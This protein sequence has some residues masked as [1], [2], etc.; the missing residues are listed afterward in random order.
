MIRRSKGSVLAIVFAVS[1]LIGT[2]IAHS[3]AAANTPEYV[4]LPVNSDPSGDPA[5]EPP[6]SPEPPAPAPPPADP[7]VTEVSPPAAPPAPEPSTS[8]PA[9]PQ[10]TDAAVESP[11]QAPPTT[12]LIVASTPQMETLDAPAPAPVEAA[13]VAAGAPVITIFAGANGTWSGAPLTFGVPGLAQTD[14]NVLGRVTDPDGIKSITYKLNSR[15]PVSMS[16]GTTSCAVGISCT[17]RLAAD[18]DFNAD[19]SAGLLLAGRNTVTIRA[20]DTTSA[21]TTVKVP[22]QYTRGRTWALPYRVQWSTVTRPD[23][24]SQVVDGRWRL[25]PAGVRTMEIG[26]DRLIAFGDRSWSSFE[27][28]VAV[29]VHRVDPNGYAP[30]STAPGVGFIPH[31]LGHADVDGSQPKW[32]FRG[33][34]GALVW[35]RD[36]KRV[37]IRNT[38]AK[39]MASAGRT[40][41][42]GVTYVLKIRAVTGGTMGPEYR[43]K[44]FPL[45]SSE[46]ARW[47]LTKTVPKGG[48]EQGSLVLVAHHMD[49][50]F[51]D[52]TV[53]R[54]PSR[55]TG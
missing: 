47:D 52:L 40:L 7:A 39:L 28:S 45:G 29:T 19:I 33:R 38:N 35:Y 11:T 24:V 31:W 1:V 21:V 2:A 34:L 32:G 22:I 4:A 13:L 18:G 14:I 25:T 43:L 3:P 17:K 12:D 41:Q 9:A 5:G 49:V 8:D 26:Y 23:A 44:V 16:L 46:P 55:T 20:V 48:P 15:K 36:T 37:E 42:P 27:A 30:P 54:L 53:R 50:T 6:Q 51:G 10:P